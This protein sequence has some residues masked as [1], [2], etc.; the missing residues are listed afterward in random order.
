MA[1]NTYTLEIDTTDAHRQVDRLSSLARGARAAMVDARRG[2]L[3]LAAVVACSAVL[4]GL[5]GGLLVLSLMA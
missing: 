1:R 3:W 4:G 2:G 5:A